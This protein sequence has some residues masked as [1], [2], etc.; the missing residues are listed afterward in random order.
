MEKKHGQ[1]PSSGG[2]WWSR[3]QQCGWS[4]GCW[5]MRSGRAVFSCPLLQAIPSL[6]GYQYHANAKLN[7]NHIVI[8]ALHCTQQSILYSCW[9]GLPYGPKKTNIEIRR[10]AISISISPSI[11]ADRWASLSR[12]WVGGHVPSE[13]SRR[14]PSRPG[15]RPGG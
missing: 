11:M 2:W 5:A 4:W 13:W 10:E 7:N 6:G 8:V 9:R 3:E 1:P 14:C 15:G 12:S